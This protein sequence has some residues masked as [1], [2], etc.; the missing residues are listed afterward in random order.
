MKKKQHM[1]KNVDEANSADQTD[2]ER[3][4]NISKQKENDCKGKGIKEL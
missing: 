4:I 2:Q 1:E 3:K